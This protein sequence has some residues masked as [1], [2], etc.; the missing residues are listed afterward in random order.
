[1]Q[2]LSIKKNNFSKNGRT[3]QAIFVFRHRRLVVNRGGSA[4][5]VVL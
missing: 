1:M 5:P 4:G 2:L 3:L